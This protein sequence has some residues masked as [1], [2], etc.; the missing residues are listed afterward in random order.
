MNENEPTP[1]EIERRIDR[2]EQ[3][4]KD[5]LASIHREIGKIDAKYVTNERFSP[6]ERIVM[7]LVV[8]VLIAVAGAIIGNVVIG[9]K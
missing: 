2:L 4:V 1:R 3:Y 9:G 6:V 8:L 7:G 5:E